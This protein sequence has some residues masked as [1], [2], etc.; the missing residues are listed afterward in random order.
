M[1]VNI[2]QNDDGS[3]GLQG[4][5]LG[6][7]GFVPASAEWTA[8]S[9]DKVV[10]VADRAYTVKGILARVEVAGT[11]AA[12]VTA[13]VKKAASGTAITSGTA[14]HTGS[15]D[16]KGTA[17]TNQALTLGADLEIAEGDTIGVDFTGALTAAV[18]AVT[19]SLAP[20]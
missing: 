13:V 8:S 6:E 16:L 20:R 9:A 1:G 19:V 18:G 12:A 17:A 15:I 7:G 4:V 11:D 3:M 2:K 14:L 10:F 5:D